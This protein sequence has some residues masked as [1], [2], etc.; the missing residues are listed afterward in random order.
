MRFVETQTERLLLEERSL[1][2]LNYIIQS[3]DTLADQE[4]AKIDVGIAK[5]IQQGGGKPIACRKGC[6]HCCYRV[7]EAAI[8]EV[9]HI[10]RVVQE[11]FS[12]EQKSSLRARVDSYVERTASFRP[13]RLDQVR[14]A[15]PFLVDD[16]CS[17]Y[18]SRPFSCL[19][20]NSTD[21]NICREIKMFK[22]AASQRP[23]W[24]ARSQLASVVRLGIRL[25]FFYSNAEMSMVD[26]GHALS[27]LFAHPEYEQD[28]LDGKDRFVASRS[29]FDS[30]NIDASRLALDHGPAFLSEL[31]AA[32]PYGKLPPKDFQLYFQGME[33]VNQERKFTEAM[34]LFKDRTA[35]QM[36]QR[37]KVPRMAMTESEID[38]SREQFLQAI[39][40][41][42][43]AEF[44]AKDA[45]NALS[46]YFTMP[47]TY[48]GRDDREIMVRQGK[49]VNDIVSKAL[50]DYTAPIE[51]KRKPG[52]LRVGYISANLTTS[53]GGRWAD[54]WLKNH[55]PDIERYAFHLGVRTDAV[56][57]R[58]RANADH[59]Y[60]LNRSVLENVR[61]I[62]EQD[63][64]VL[65]YPD[66]G[67]HPRNTQYSAMRLAR[68]QCTAWGHP[69]TTGLSTIDYYLSSELMEPEDG[70]RFYTEKLV[71]LP[72]AGLVFE[73]ENN[74]FPPADRTHFGLP[75]K[76][77]IIVMVQT[78]MKVVPRFDHLYAE[79]AERA[80]V[81]IVF[82][83]SSPPG[84]AKL[85]RKRLDLAGV[86]THWLPHMPHTE[87]LALLQLADVSIDPPMWSGGNSTTQTLGVGTPV[88]TLPGPFMRSRHSYAFLKMSG[89]PG[90]IAGDEKDYVDLVCDFDRQKAAFKDFDA[91]PIYNDVGV[92]RAL[93]EFLLGLPTS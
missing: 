11:S 19:G 41:F 65:I 76:G 31:E 51:S 60:W 38:E 93:D 7:A 23:I 46:G 13:D 30:E 12:D 24:Q 1:A 48:Q 69:D 72:R 5:A 32:G 86:R 81:P 36:M 49:F 47:L 40:D 8:S 61:F 80:G 37:I 52:K 70:D 74:S 59:F 92:V 66:I 3:A 73:H 33:L 20:L 89:A 2:K 79:I 88:V 83:E 75:E 43:A 29:A 91:A 14:A 78:S 6:S 62:R 85:L 64:D 10:W 82:L 9:L 35:G 45:F 67:L 42:E 16:A 56:T 17:I 84:D 53:N 57:D 87:F 44:H 34:A 4:E 55:G 54:A 90:L 15:C 63:L 77:P 39:D 50:Q 21:A 27:I 26:L 71:R 25:G 68:V 18:E 22:R 58:F 28:Y